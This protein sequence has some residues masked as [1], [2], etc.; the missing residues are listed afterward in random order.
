[1]MEIK[2]TG[3]TAA[4][5]R[6]QLTDWLQNL[7]GNAEPVQAK[8]AAKKKAEPA[9]TQQTDETAAAEEKPKTKKA[10][11]Q[12]TLEGVPADIDSKTLK[13]FCA[14]AMREGVKVS[15]IINKISGGIP[16]IDDIDE[17][18]YPQIYAEVKQAQEELNG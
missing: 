3:S 7:G 10:P 9:K 11:E 16:K 15:E 13:K 1:M 12:G 17:S 14:K 18:L 5:I 2:F 6:D 4:E 8:P